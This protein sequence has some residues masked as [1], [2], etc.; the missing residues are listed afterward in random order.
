MREKTDESAAPLHGRIRCDRHLP[1]C[2]RT[3]RTLGRSRIGRPR[4]NL[5]LV[6]SS[7]P[8]GIV[9]LK[10]DGLVTQPSRKE[11]LRAGDEVLP[12]GVDAD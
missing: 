4:G 5:R 8:K 9:D 6:R 11:Q 7:K 1:L 2:C 10:V 12:T 3:T